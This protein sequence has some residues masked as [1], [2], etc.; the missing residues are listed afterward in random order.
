MKKTFFAVAVSVLLGTGCNA[1]AN[2]DMPSG[3]TMGNMKSE[4]GMMSSMMM[5]MD[6]NGDGML[7]KEEFIKGHEAMFDRMKGP[8]GMISLKDMQMIGMG[9]MDSGNMMGK[10]HQMPGGMEKGVK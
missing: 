3:Q 6:T 2:R 1:M 10:D 7:S 4:H 9:M 8:N 5:K